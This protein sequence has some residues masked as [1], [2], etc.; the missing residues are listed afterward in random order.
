MSGDQLEASD[1]SS[2]PELQVTVVRLSRAI[3]AVLRLSH[4]I[5]D[6]LVANMT[7]RAS[8]AADHLPFTAS[9]A[10][11]VERY[12]AGPLFALWNECRAVDALRLVVTGRRG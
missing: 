6:V 2:T 3:D 11:G 7:L 12:G 8:L 1:L 5:D 9:M 10:E 4:A